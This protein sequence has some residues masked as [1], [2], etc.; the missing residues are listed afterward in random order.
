MFSLSQAQDSSNASR[1]FPPKAF[2]IRDCTDAGQGSRVFLPVLVEDALVFFGD[3]HAAI[4]NGIITGTGIEC[5]MKVRARINLVNDRKLERPIIAQGGAVHF[6]GVGPSVEEAT[7]DA[8][9]RAIDFAVAR[10]SLDR[11]EAFTLLS[12]IGELRV[13]TSPRPVMATRLIVPEQQL[14][15]AGW[16]GELP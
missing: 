9:R 1:L 7:E 15:A 11:E 12:I 13:G 5:S 6:V 2:G 10:T 16:N 8:A 3:P 14:R 4:S